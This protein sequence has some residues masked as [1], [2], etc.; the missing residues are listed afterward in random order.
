MTAIVFPHVC[1]NGGII[2]DLS[3]YGCIPGNLGLPE[4][5]QP[6]GEYAANNGAGIVASEFRSHL[7]LGDAAR[8]YVGN[9]TNDLPDMSFFKTVSGGFS[10][11]QGIQFRFGSV[12][13]DGY[14]SFDVPFPNECHTIVFGQA[15]GT[16]AWVF[17]PMYKNLTKSGFEF[18]GRAYS[19]V[20]GVQPVGESACYL[21]IGN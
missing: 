5:F 2:T 7:Q 16:N 1:C 10:L 15:F 6:K 8:R 18:A 14:K 11:P 20:S 17:S 3:G 9:N 19:G 13:G 4:L 12:G 21:A